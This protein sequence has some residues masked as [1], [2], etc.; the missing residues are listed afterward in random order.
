MKSR[1]IGQFFNLQGK[2]IDDNLEVIVDK[3]AKIYST[4]NKTYETY[5]EDIVIPKIGY[6]KAIKAL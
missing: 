6:S 1:A 3:I 4:G 2:K 5:E